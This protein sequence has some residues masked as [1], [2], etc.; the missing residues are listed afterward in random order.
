VPRRWA[1]QALGIPE[2]QADEPTLPAR[3]Q[4]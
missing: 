2:V 3:G 4:V 1:H